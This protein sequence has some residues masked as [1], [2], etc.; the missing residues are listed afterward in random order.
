MSEINDKDIA[1]LVMVIDDEPAVRSLIQHI[2]VEAGY[3]VEAVPDG[4]VALAR[5]EACAPDVVITDV[6]MEP[7]D[8]IEVMRDI[9]KLLPEIPIIA[10]SGGGRLGSNQYLQMC[11]RLGA[12]STIEKPFRPGELLRVVEDAITSCK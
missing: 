8:G 5:L 7:L 3:R 12:K 9:R 2:L 11:V 10:M 1:P 4:A 6:V